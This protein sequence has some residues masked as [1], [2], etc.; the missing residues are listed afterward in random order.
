[1]CVSTWRD[2]KS[3]LVMSYAENL[4][5]DMSSSIVGRADRLRQSGERTALCACHEHPRVGTAGN[6]L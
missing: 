3:N 5:E 4:S 6:L 1:M 2:E